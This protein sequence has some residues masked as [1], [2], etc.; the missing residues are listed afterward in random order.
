M[1]SLQAVKKRLTGRGAFQT[2]LHTSAANLLIM[3]LSTLTSIVTA[4]LFGVAGKGEFSAILFW[5]TLLAGLVSFGLP[6][7]LIFNMRTNAGRATEY[8]RAGFLFQIPVSLIVGIAAWIYLPVWLGQY[9]EAVIQVARWYTVLTLPMLLAVNLLAALT[10]SMDK[11]NLYNGLRL[12]VPLSNLAGLLVL[13][14]I[15]KLTIPYASFAFF[16][17]SLMVIFWSLY[18][19][20]RELTFNW[21]KPFA[22][23]IVFKSLF[24]YGGRV[25]GVELLGTLY[26]QCDKLIIL[27]LLRPKD[28]GLYT[29]V[30]TLSRVFNVVQ[31]AISNVIFPKVTG[32]DKDKIIATVGRAFRLSFLLMTAAVIPG[33]IIGRFLLGLLFGAQFLEAGNAF[34]L[35]SLECILGGGSWILASS[36]NAMGRP[37][38]VV[39]RQAVA[40]VITVGLFFVFTPLYGLNGIAFALLLGAVIRIIITI[41]A[42]RVVFKVRIA[43][44][45]FD[46]DDI[47]FLF[48]RL[49][50]SMPS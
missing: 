47:R 35:L 43:D 23:R 26:S 30:Y 7:S 39:I 36:F 21:F 34:Y 11:F 44:I 42:M 20:R 41:A 27:S 28:F 10:Q 4:R 2:I 50:R 38:L 13:W 45:L 3:I 22:D 12:Y 1:I 32:M 48:K 16:A 15:G 9:S 5:P 18:R 17:T 33:M 25:F 37:G 19:L 6:T 14:A 31:M 8:V 49:S 24:G 46:K 29:V 40:L